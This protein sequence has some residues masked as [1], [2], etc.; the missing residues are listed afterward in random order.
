MPGAC[1]RW[2]PQQA[3]RSTGGLLG[4]I[5]AE[6]REASPPDPYPSQVGPHLS[7]VGPDL[8]CRPEQ[9]DASQGKVL[10]RWRAPSTIFPK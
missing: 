4:I 10:H 9:G 2:G 7:A 6:P 8:H 3:G 1:Y 5:H